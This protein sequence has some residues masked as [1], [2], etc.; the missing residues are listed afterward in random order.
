MTSIFDA[1]KRH[2]APVELYLFSTGT[3]EDAYI[4]YTDAEEPVAFQGKVYQPITIQHGKI[5]ASASLDKSTLGVEVPL[6]AEI[7]ELFRIFPPAQVVGLII[8][9]GNQGDADQNFPV[10]WTGR[11]LSCARPEP[12]GP[13]KAVLSCEPA[14][15]STKRSGLRR[16]YQTTCPHVL[17]GTR[18]K[19]SQAAATVT[20]A[21][22]ALGANTITFA[23]GWN[24]TRPAGKFTTG[25]TTWQ[26]TR[27]LERRMILAVAGN[28]LTLAGPT[29]DL[30][31]GADVDV[32]LGCN[33]LMT[34][35]QDLHTNI[36]NF[37][38]QPWIPLKNPV[39]HNNHDDKEA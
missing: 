2:A 22:T 37:G 39:N 6:G 27:G 5:A 10:I 20:A 4:A 7:A 11:V 30:I 33:H 32:A 14:S 13:Q 31:V 38:G 1:N 16:H 8:R 18:C 25:M 36:L 26:G 28:T 9:S 24:G 21:A 17:Y 35:C 19:A 12:N 15:T 29:T 3:E 23:A 34:D